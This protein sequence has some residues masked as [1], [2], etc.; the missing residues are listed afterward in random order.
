M[1]GNELPKSLQQRISENASK[2]SQNGQHAGDEV[3]SPLILMNLPPFFS[4]LSVKIGVFGCPMCMTI[5]DIPING[6]LL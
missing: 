4:S 3:G 1:R 6:E 2:E 5:N